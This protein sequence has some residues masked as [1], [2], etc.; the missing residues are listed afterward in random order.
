M[1]SARSAFEEALRERIVIID[2]AM[3]TMI[4]RH[5]LGEDDYRG[6]YF[7]KHP[8]PLKG[9]NELLV[10]TR[11]EIIES[12]HT[13][14]LDAGADI[15]ETNT[16]NA[17]AISMADYDLVS[18]VAA[19][20]HA[21]ATVAR[22][23][24]DAVSARTGR[25]RFVAGALGPTTKSLSLS[26]KVEDPAFRAVT[27][28]E[29]VAV[30]AAQVDALVDGG[31]D[32]I[33]PE[34][35]FDT[36][37][38]KAAL[39]A[40]EEVFARRQIRLPVMASV[41]I[42]DRS[43][44]TLSGQ[45][46]EAAYTSLEHAPLTTVG[47]NCA[48]GPNDMRPYIAALARQANVAVHCYPNAGLP[49]PLSPTGF[50]ETPES[51]A[52]QLAEFARNGW[53]NVVGGC[54]GTTPDHIAAIARA[55]APY[56]PRALPKQDATLTQLS[57]LEPYTLRPES[58][59]SLIGER[60]NVTGSK[61]FRR[62]VMEGHY[63]AAVQV[64]REQVEGGANV[65]DV[66][67]D[68]GMLDGVAAMTRFL[69][70]IGSEPDV[71]RI[72]VMV[73]SSRWEILE[74]G[75]KCLQGK[76]IV[77]SISLKEGEEKFVAQARR[78]RQYGA[79]VVV[80]CFDETGQAVTAEHKVAVA[81]RAFK[82]LTETVGFAP[83]DVIVDP[84]ILTVG[85]GI[86]EH[87]E[88][89]LNFVA[90][91]REI[92]R[93]C[94]G[95]K[96][97]G[98]VS[99]IS[100][101]FRGNDPVREAMH[102]AFLYR[103]IEAGL[104]MGIV[105]AGQLAVYD[106]IEPT[107]RTLVEDVLW[108]RRPDATER[109]IAYSAANKGEARSQQVDLAWR[110]RPVADRVAHALM[111]GIDEYIEADMA[112]CLAQYPTPLS[113]IEGPLMDGMSVVGDLFGEGKMF[114]PQVVKSARVMKKAVAWLEPYMP[115]AEGVG[116]GTVL[117]ATV[118]GDV[119]DIG[120]NIVGVVLACNGYRVVDMGVM[121]P[122]EKILAAARAEKADIVGL[123]GLITPS[124]DEMVHVAREMKR[125][126]FT[127]P[128]LIGGATTSAKHTAVK[129]APSYQ[130]TVHVRDASRSVNVVTRLLSARDRETF[131]SDNV[132]EQERLRQ[133]HAARQEQALWPLGEARARAPRLRFDADTVASP[134]A[135]GV[136]SAR[137]VDLASLVPFIDWAPFFHAWEFRG[138]FPA[139]LDDPRYGGKTREL[140]DD[141]QKLLSTL[142]RDK[143]L[144]ANAVWG[145]FAAARDGDDVVLYTDASRTTESARLP[146]L[147][148]QEPTRNGVSNC[149]ADFVSPRESGV[150]DH[151][152][153]FAVTA[154]LGADAVVAEFEAKH[155]DYGAILTKALADRLAEA[156][157]EWLHAEIRAQWGFAEDLSHGEL[158]AEKYRGIRPAPGYPACPDH[159]LKRTIFS[160]LDAPAQAE[161][162]LTESLAMYP[163]A[164]VSG[165]VFGHPD[166]HYFS[167]TAVGRDQCL[168][169]AQRLDRP[170][171][172]VE[173]WLA[174]VL[175]YDPE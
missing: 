75:L 144:R 98:G 156:L 140:F 104:D 158:L 83:G 99:N 41:T 12:I 130:G 164:S 105:N 155:D 1:V 117:L 48:L 97:S 65:L 100:F 119:H 40:I 37:N 79:A 127:L 159:T 82:I 32:L 55:V 81:E 166:A 46:I 54:C 52:P 44:R 154:G 10:L 36:L 77:N 29:M 147:R 114:L 128:L 109:L 160:L 58:N 45:T 172:E 87:N 110:E 145:F 132:E 64:A 175:A 59:F 165:I 73:D 39:F 85:T 89:A 116:K 62:L 86:D 115:K 146:M 162:A 2:G 169:Y 113:I 136:A 170:L 106:Q 53:L 20:N 5:P 163:A 101:S 69:N 126:G 93:R 129:I 131:L 95:I 34:T 78:I 139:I 61:K 142:L 6:S 168:D 66:N 92:K 13:A 4:Q 28:D 33:L 70:Q 19:L 26:P 16:F 9:C 133:R 134:K 38:L 31:V 125:E 68:D 50:P 56:A 167:V 72:P 161:M 80:M 18:M 137:E 94:P 138:T 25:R 71:A 107:L 120:K 143:R 174:P 7:S 43:G 90:A 84:N 148:Q 60:T 141:A 8:T 149:L 42:T 57:G 74:A 91:T 152:A 124:L 17:N 23:A 63:E 27:F 112:D 123:S 173:K 121:V 135:L 111:Q 21:A 103:A 11:P 14:Y 102:A 150:A 30:Y 51:L 15:I 3:G 118:K 151:V 49:D 157:T 22:K 24:A 67:L 35:S 171:R 88:Y 47:I 108:N 153:L 122:S 76:G 96:V